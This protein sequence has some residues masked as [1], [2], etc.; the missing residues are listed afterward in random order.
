LMNI[1]NLIR[2]STLHAGIF[3][4]LWNEMSSKHVLSYHTEATWLLLENV[5]C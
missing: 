2:V 3:P 4:F 5:C 1:N